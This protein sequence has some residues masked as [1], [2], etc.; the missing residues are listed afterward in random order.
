MDITIRPLAAHHLDAIA[1]LEQI[2]FSTPWTRGQLQ[3]ELDNP[4]ARVY[5]AEGEDGAILGYGGLH[6][7]LDE[8]GI[9]NIAVFPHARR[10]GV[11]QAV[12]AAMDRFC[13]SAGMAFLTLEV[14]VSNAAAIAL[15]EKAGFQSLGVRKRF[16]THPVE[17]GMIMTKFYTE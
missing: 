15:Y 17:D 9:T 4:L 14:R 12:L 5:V 2:C 11:A 8:A 6:Y 3:E 16:Y 13:W 1:E 7:V 10:Q